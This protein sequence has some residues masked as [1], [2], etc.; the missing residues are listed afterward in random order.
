MA[1]ETDKAKKQ[2]ALS[3]LDDLAK[4]LDEGRLEGTFEVRGIFWKMQLLQ[5]HEVNW[6]NGF[7]RTNSTL[8]ML[9]SRRAPTLAIGIRAI[10][11]SEDTM[12]SV[13]QYFMDEWEAERG[14]LDATVKAILDNANEYIQQY[15]F[16]E[17]LFKWLS[18]RPPEFV[19]ALWVKWQSLEE[20]RTEA[21]KAM[22]KSSVEDG[23]LSKTPPTPSS[24][25]SAQTA[26]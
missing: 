10:G 3:L 2:G 9:T 19:S 11:K 16:A 21:E 22:G 24:V 1:K 12:K 20:R 23:T 7:Q 8:S 18:V 6:A 14:E 26:T 25:P 13:R 4:E 17:Q 15:W 5:D